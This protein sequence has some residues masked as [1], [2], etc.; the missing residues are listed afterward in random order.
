MFLGL[1]ATAFARIGEDEKQIEARYGKAGKVLEE[2]SSTR[3]VGYM[4][5]A[6]AVVVDF[7]NG[8]SRREGFA[9]PDT[10]RLSDEEIKQILNVSAV[11]NTTWTEGP[12]KQGDRA[13]QRSDGKAQAFLPARGTFLVI[14]DVTFV[15]PTEKNSP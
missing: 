7:Q 15:Q 9:K 6:F 10:S 12:G 11:E 4:A 13:W 8:I 14:Q 1:A 3:K 5:G 2:T